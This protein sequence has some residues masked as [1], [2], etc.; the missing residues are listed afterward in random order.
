MHLYLSKAPF[1]APEGC[2]LYKI[3]IT[4]NVDGRKK[5][6]SNSSVNGEFRMLGHKRCLN[7]R[8]MEAKVF[9]ALDYYRYQDNRE[10]FVFDSDGQ[11]S[12]IVFET[13]DRLQLGACLDPKVITPDGLLEELENR[14]SG[15]E[16]IV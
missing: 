7:A 13:L 3:G 1:I 2:P 6:L 5:T 4:K 14:W 8:G 10:F 9:R 11:A 12:R 15:D 16:Y